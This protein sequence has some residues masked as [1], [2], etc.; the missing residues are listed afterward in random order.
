MSRLERVAALYDIHGNLPALDAVLDEVRTLGVDR[1]I[2]GGDVLPGPMPREALERLLEIEIPTTF[3]YGNGDRAV[4][5]QLDAPTPDAVTY[6]G[7]SSGVPL[8]SPF[9]EYIRWNA[10]AVADLQ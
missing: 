3:I 5:A 7:T 10:R 4:L 2:V 9:Q 6:W 8:P 1:V